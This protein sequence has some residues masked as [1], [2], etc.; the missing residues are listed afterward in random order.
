MTGPNVRHGICV[1]GPRDSQTLAATQPGRV[2]HPDDPNGFYVYK[3]A[4]TTT[5]G[6]WTWVKT[7]E[8]V[9]L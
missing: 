6:Q 4:V 7:K 9:K 3:A 2:G 5:P 8:P 1:G